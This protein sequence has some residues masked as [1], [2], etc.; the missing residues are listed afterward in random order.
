MSATEWRKLPN[1]EIE[2]L[3]YETFLGRRGKNP[4]LKANRSVFKPHRQ[5]YKIGYKDIYFG[6]LTSDCT[7]INTFLNWK[8]KRP[9][10]PLHPLFISTYY[11]VRLMKLVQPSCMTN[12]NTSISVSQTY[13]TFAALF[14]S[15]QLHGIVFISR[16][17]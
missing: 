14:P 16:N 4:L 9:L 5:S 1:I 11:F 8:S 15:I 17:L 13:L 3:K 12:V 2:L 10:K 6:L 7:N